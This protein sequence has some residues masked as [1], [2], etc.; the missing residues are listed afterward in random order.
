MSE[1]SLNLKCGTEDLSSF[2]IV[3]AHDLGNWDPFPYKLP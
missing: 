3:L 1:T 2:Q